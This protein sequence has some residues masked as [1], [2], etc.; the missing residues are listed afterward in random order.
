MGSKRKR[1]VKPFPTLFADINVLITLVIETVG[2]NQMT[3]TPKQN[4]RDEVLKRMLKMKPKPHKGEKQV[5]R[6]SGQTK[7]AKPSRSKPSA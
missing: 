2:P 4:T 3:E 5:R 7:A 1:C 6:P